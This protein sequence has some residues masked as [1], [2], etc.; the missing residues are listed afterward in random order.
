MRSSSFVLALF[1]CGPVVHAQ[2]YSPQSSYQP[3]YDPNFAYQQWRHQHPFRVALTGFCKGWSQWQQQQMITHTGIY[4]PPLQMPVNT[5]I[6]QYMQPIEPIGGS[7]HVTRS[8]NYGSHKR[9]QW[10]NGRSP[11]SCYRSDTCRGYDG[12]E[13]GA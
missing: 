6:S 1:L 12:G 5:D 8:G 10:D 4:A 2:T 11:L 7:Y 13:R 9:S 3:T